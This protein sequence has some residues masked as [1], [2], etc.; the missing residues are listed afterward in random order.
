MRTRTV[1]FAGCFALVMLTVGAWASHEWDFGIWESPGDASGG[2]GMQSG[3]QVDPT[4]KVL[5]W[6]SG[7]VPGEI[8]QE[9][10][11]DSMGMDLIAVYEGEGASSGQIQIDGTTQQKM[12]I[13]LGRVVTGPLVRTLRI[14]G[15]VDYDE[16]TLGVVTTK[17]DGWIEKLYVE[18]TGA[19]IHKGDALFDIYSPELYAAQKE[20]LVAL[21]SA[22]RARASGRTGGGRLDSESLLEGARTKLEYYD[23]PSD[24]IEELGRTGTATKTLT[25]RSAFTGIVTHKQAVEGE[26]VSAG[27]ALLRIADL[28]RIWVIGRVFEHDLPFIRVGQAARMTLSYIPGKTFVGRVTYVYPYLEKGT[29]EISIRM[30][31]FNPGYELKP[32]MYATIKLREE[33][34]PAVTLVPDIAVM[35]TGERSV[36]FVSTE[37]GRFKLRDV[38]T[39]VRSTDNMLQVISGLSPGDEVVLSG[40][41]LLDSESRLREAALKFLEPKSPDDRAPTPDA[42]GVANDSPTGTQS[43]PEDP[44][45]V[46]PMPEHASILYDSPGPCPICGKSMDLVPTAETDPSSHPVNDGEDR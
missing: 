31:F 39:G 25:L 14:V 41:F 18:E 5:Y 24:T 43:R 38:R 29:R 9:P 15:Y 40:Q 1:L 10:G 42:K 16:T 33:L 36:A 23:V 19:Q 11:K 21:N 35:K 28:S 8:H 32:G 34:D 13:R 17:V 26:K 22:R 7:M 45:Y 37:P 4:R 12:G 27:R 44:H 46:C 3:S 6:K 20:Y 2:M 30:E